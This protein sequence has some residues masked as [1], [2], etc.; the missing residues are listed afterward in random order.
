[1]NNQFKG[2][3]GKKTGVDNNSSSMPGVI[4][5]GLLMLAV[6]FMYIEYDQNKHKTEGLVSANQAEE[7]AERMEDQWEKENGIYQLS[8]GNLEING[9]SITEITYY[10]DHD[11]YLVKKGVKFND[12]EAEQTI[13]IRQYA[14]WECMGEKLDFS[15]DTGNGKLY[16]KTD[17]GNTLLAE[18][19][20]I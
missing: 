13:G 16:V 1:M 8:S 10:P 19:D 12:F 6:F 9:E 2:T 17:I 18:F 11:E 20:K 4:I 3:N 15:F 5:V 7:M 14:V